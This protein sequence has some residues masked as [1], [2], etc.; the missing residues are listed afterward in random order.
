[1]NQ[2]DQSIVAAISGIG[3]V[4]TLIFGT[5]AIVATPLPMWIYVLIVLLECAFVALFIA[6]KKA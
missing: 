1:M 2:S 4:L 5:F 3:G 6:N